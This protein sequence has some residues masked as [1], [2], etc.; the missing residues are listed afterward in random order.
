MFVEHSFGSTRNVTIALNSDCLK[1]SALK[2]ITIKTSSCLN[3]RRTT[4]KY[5]CPLWRAV[6]DECGQL[7][8]LAY[9]TAVTYPQSYIAHSS[10]FYESY[11]DLYIKNCINSNDYSFAQWLVLCMMNMDKCKPNI[12]WRNHWEVQQRAMP[13][14]YVYLHLYCISTYCSML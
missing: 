6:I 4:Q 3:M 1:I 5:V 2:K 7:H 13:L 14:R 9:A 12:R 11:G 8:R 10:I